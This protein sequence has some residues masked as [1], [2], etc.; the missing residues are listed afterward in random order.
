MSDEAFGIIVGML[1]ST[2]LVLGAIGMFKAV[3]FIWRRLTGKK[4]PE[5]EMVSVSFRLSEGGF[6]S[7]QER[8]SLQ[9]FAGRL[10]RLLK[11]LD[12]GEYDGDEFGCGVGSL[13]FYGPS[14]EEIWQGIEP[15]VREKA[16][17]DPLEATL[18]FGAG[19]A[20]RKTIAL[21]ESGNPK[22]P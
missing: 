8:R 12:A 14:A 7:T 9:R 4:E 20:R 16:P 11:D 22:E 5:N 21:S 17:L 10:E 13:Y 18:I 3:R 19:K 2:F 1:L 15:V 6:G